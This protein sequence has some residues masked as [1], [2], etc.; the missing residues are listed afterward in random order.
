[1]Q[2]RVL[3]AGRRSGLLDLQGSVAAAGHGALGG[4]ARERP[5]RPRQ[6]RADIHRA[7]SARQRSARGGAGRERHRIRPRQVTSACCSSLHLRCRFGT[8]GSCAGRASSYAQIAIY[9]RSLVVVTPSFGPAVTDVGERKACTVV[10][11]AIK[12]PAWGIPAVC[13]GHHCGWRAWFPGCSDEFH[14]PGR[15]AA[16]GRGPAGP[17]PE[18]RRAP[19]PGAGRPGARVPA[20]GQAGVLAGARGVVPAPPTSHWPPAAASASSRAGSHRGCVMPGRVA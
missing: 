13:R 8:A 19:G 17:G 15:P 6:Q 7:W 10:P 20:A 9:V 14:R 16:Q 5:R 4:R 3:I 11:L 1:V 12:E 2:V 18:R